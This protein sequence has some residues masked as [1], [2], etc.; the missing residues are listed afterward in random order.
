MTIEQIEEICMQLPAAER[1]IKW[2][3]DLVFSVGKKIF[4]IVDLVGPPTAVSFKVEAENYESMADRLYFRPAPYFA[5]YNWVMINDASKMNLVEWKRHLLVS[6]NLVV[7]NLLKK[8]K[9]E[10]SNIST[11]RNAQT[12]L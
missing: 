1:D 11:G 6:Y 10:L 2:K 4:C 12:N 5:R 8:V 9:A 3:S 7:E